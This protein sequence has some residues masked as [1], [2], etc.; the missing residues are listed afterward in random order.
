[1]PLTFDKKRDT[2]VC[3]IHGDVDDTGWVQCWA[4]GGEGGN[5]MY[6][7]DGVNYS[8]GEEW[9]TCDECNGKGGF[10]VCGQCNADNPDVEW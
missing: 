1:M 7:E 4:C 5:D 6:E 3:S 10:V 2:H 9:S 8:P